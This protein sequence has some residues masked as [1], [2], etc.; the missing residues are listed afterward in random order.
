MDEKCLDGHHSRKEPLFK[1]SPLI[2]GPFS[3]PA[4]YSKCVII[5]L[6]KI[7]YII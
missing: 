4:A 2:C 7:G 5:L 3:V 1:M 6:K